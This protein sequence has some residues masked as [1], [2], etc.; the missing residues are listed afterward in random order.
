[1]VR[2]SVSL[3]LE[4]N[5]PGRGLSSI[6]EHEINSLRR[7]DLS[8]CSIDEID[9]LEVFSDITELCLRNNN[10]KLIENLIFLPKLEVLDVSSNAIP[11]LDA[12]C[13]GTYLIFLET[14]L[15]W[16]IYCCL[17]SDDIPGS[18]RKLIISGNPCCQDPNIVSLVQARCRDL[19]VLAEYTDPSAA[20]ARDDGVS[21]EQ[22]RKSMAAVY[23]EDA[24]KTA[25]GRSP[26]SDDVKEH[27]RPGE[28]G[29]STDEDAL[30]VDADYSALDADSILRQLVHRKCEMEGMEQFDID[31]TVMVGS[32]SINFKCSVFS[33][34]V[35]YRC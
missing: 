11:D 19:E 17:F 25:R 13:L 34:L 16:M 4:K 30:P 31:H 32:Y 6:L 35:C 7:I 27:T 15:L 24:P 1:M 22:L 10:I 12:L 26:K 28:D 29:P 18:L 5:F 33:N 2:I 20:S 9:N 3:I 21:E 8:R 23:E 14:S